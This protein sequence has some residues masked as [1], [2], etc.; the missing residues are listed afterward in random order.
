MFAGPL[1]VAETGGKGG[2]GATL[3]PLGRSVVE[4]FRA[5]EAGV[6]LAAGA[7]LGSLEA[8][9]RRGELP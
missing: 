8:D 7:E 9:L 2:G 6:W 4:R 3:T 1:V 5:V